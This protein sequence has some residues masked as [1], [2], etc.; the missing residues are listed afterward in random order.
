MWNKWFPWWMRNHHWNWNRTFSTIAWRPSRPISVISLNKRTTRRT[1][2]FDS[3]Q[4]ARCDFFYSRWHFYFFVFLFAVFYGERKEQKERKKGRLFF[5]CY[6]FQID[7]RRI[8]IRQWKI[9][10]AVVHW[11]TQVH[12]IGHFIAEKSI[13]RCWLPSLPLIGVSFFIHKRE[14]EK[15]TH[16]DPHCWSVSAIYNQELGREFSLSLDLFSLADTWRSDLRNNQHSTLGENPIDT[17]KRKE[18]RYRTERNHTMLWS[19]RKQERK[20]PRWI[21]MVDISHS[22]YLYH[23]TRRSSV[24]GNHESHQILNTPCDRSLNDVF[25][26]QHL[27]WY[28]KC[29]RVAARK[30][31]RAICNH[32]NLNEALFSILEAIVKQNISVESYTCRW[33]KAVQMKE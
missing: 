12:P 5:Y 14:D 17:E 24:F 25:L 21:S 33:L 30:L 18:R 20:R 13:P 31:V 3:C 6:W 2:E 27:Q 23:D 8:P 15:R 9:S 10:N 4:I 16:P 29:D 22:W 28:H 19:K 32:I 26:N 7:A 1:S 11:Y